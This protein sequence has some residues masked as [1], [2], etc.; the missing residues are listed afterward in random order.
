M[1][2]EV[3]SP[4]AMT[5]IQDRG[6]FGMQ[7]LGFT[8]CGA[9]DI[10][11]MMLANALVGN[12]AGEAVIEFTLSGGLYRFHENCRIALTGADMQAT[13]NGV[14]CNQNHAIEIC[15][16]DLLQLGF[17]KTGCRTY[18]AVAGGLEIEEVLGSKSTDRKCRIG[19]FSGRAFMT[20]DRISFRSAEWADN[21]ISLTSLPRGITTK[22]NTTS[23]PYRIRVVMGPQED[24]FSR[25]G[26]DTFLNSPYTIGSD[27]NRMAC[28]LTGKSITSLKGTDILSDGIA[29]GSIQVAGNGLPMIM[30]ADRQTIGGYAKIATV[31]AADMTILGQCRPQDT[32]LFE[33]ISLRKAVSIYKSEYRRMQRLFQ[34]TGGG[35][36]YG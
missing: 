34:K 15:K 10:K 32:I 12:Y 22:M 4:G 2:I 24:Y 17:A 36:H 26:I 21:Q 35:D 8:T 18:L 29:P 1:S 14:L 20:G 30:L 5:L 33:K 13:I 9:A 11:S 28:K 16:E 6:R 3:L 31:I 23:D 19:G 7:E 27:S 25:E